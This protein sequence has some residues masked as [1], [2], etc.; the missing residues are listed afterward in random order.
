MEYGGVHV[1]YAD[2]RAIATK[3]T[4]LIFV[5]SVVTGYMEH[6]VTGVKNGMTK[7]KI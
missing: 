1:L 3:R 2:G 4:I 5:N 7:N 6:I